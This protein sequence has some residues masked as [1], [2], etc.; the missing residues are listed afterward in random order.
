MQR[1]QPL[2]QGGFALLQGGYGGGQ[3]PRP[4]AE[5]RPGLFGVPPGPGHGFIGPLPA[6]HRQPHAALVALGAQNFNQPHLPGGGQMGAAAGAQ[7]GP[8]CVHQPHRP[9]Q[10][11]FAAVG[12]GGQLPG[13]GVP[14]PHRPVRPH[15][16]VGGG[17]GGGQLL[18]RQGQAHIH[19]HG[20]AADVK[21]HIVRPE[22]PV[23]GPAQNV[24][25][26]VLLHVVQ[27]PGPVNPA[28]HRAA[29]RQRRGGAVQNGALPHAGFGHGHVVQRAGVAGLAAAFRVEGGPVQLHRVPRFPG[30]AG[31]HPGGKGLC[32]GVG[33]V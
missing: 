6:G 21:P 31:H 17:L 20:G 5:Q 28:L 19:P 24:L 30:G 26:G 32:R 33:F 16:G 9:V 18:R 22:H 10:L 12:Q 8:A 25:A 13:L 15:G 2:A 23:N 14:A 3:T 1:G 29:H 27:P 11:L 7:V 4:G